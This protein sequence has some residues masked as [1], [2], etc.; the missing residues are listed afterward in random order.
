MSP[1]PRWRTLVTLALSAVGFA[2]VVPAHAAPS[3]PSD[4]APSA[5]RAAAV[6]NAT[7]KKKVVGTGTARSCTYAR[8]AKAVRSGGDITFDC[9]P[10]P[11]TIV[12]KK[13]LVVCNTH[14]CKDTWNGGKRVE[15]VRINGGGK[16]TLSGGGTRGI[17]YA[18]TCDHRL[19]WID[20]HCDTQTTPHV[21]LRNITLRDGNAT[22]GPARYD[23][24]LGGGGGGAVAMRGGRLTVKNATFTKNRCV[25]RHSDAGGGAIRITGQRATARIYGSTFRS[26]RC[27]NGGAVSSLH[28]PMRIKDST[29][30][31]NRATGT[32]ASSGKGGNGGAIYFDGTR[33]NVR[34]E[35]TRIQENRAPEGGPG[36]FYVSN[37]RTGSLTIKGSRIT[38]NTGA[39][40]WTGGTKSIFFLGKKLTK[41]GST[42][43]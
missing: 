14:T 10:K 9:G 6:K 3:S 2:V 25:T 19:G 11:V 23:G 16:V 31:K 5:V 42:I 26:N 34:V 8:L 36:I 7:V 21:E 43:S 4:A 15:R 35:G 12:V 40:F 22:Q 18:N 28:A 20:A 27:A 39:S 32:G 33:Q 1:S 37:D 30:L 38:K 17:L 41:T 29:F 24:V 13:T